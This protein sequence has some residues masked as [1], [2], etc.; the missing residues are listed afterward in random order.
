MSTVLPNKLL[1]LMKP[2]DRAKLGPAG[3]TADEAGQK[4]AAG[5]ER[6][7]HALFAADMDRRGC[8]VIRG[9]TDRKSTIRK[10]WPD[11]T[12]LRAGKVCCIEF[13]AKGGV[14][15]DDQKECLAD[16]ERNGTPATVAWD[17]ATAIDFVK[18]HL[19]ATTPDRP[20]DPVTRGC[21]GQ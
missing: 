17:L 5:E 21:G 19:L 20:S 3:L 9:R 1:K 14:L 18:A 10:G 16:L 15:S 4:W 8:L 7:L 12:I 6:K 13:K 2:E 11:F